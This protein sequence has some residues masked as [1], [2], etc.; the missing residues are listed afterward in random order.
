MRT[1]KVTTCTSMYQ[2]YWRPWDPEMRD[3]WVRNIPEGSMTVENFPFIRMQCG[4]MN[5]RCI[6]QMVA[7]KERCG[8]VLLSHRYSYAGKFQ[9]LAQYS[10][11]PEIS[12]VS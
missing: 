1:F 11:C 8:S 5:F 10:P 9:S 3:I 6:C 2:N 7:C 4:I 12:D